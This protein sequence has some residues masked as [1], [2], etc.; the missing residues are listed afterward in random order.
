MIDSYQNVNGC[1][2]Y[3]SNP[4]TKRE[5]NNGDSSVSTI[6]DRHDSDRWR[7]TAELRE[8][9]RP[10]TLTGRSKHE[11]RN[12]LSNGIWSVG[13]W[14]SLHV[15]HQP[16]EWDIN[17]SVHRH[18]ECSWFGS[19]HLM[20]VHGRWFCP[21][22]EGVPDGQ[23]CRFGSMSVGGSSR[24][25]AYDWLWLIADERLVLRRCVSDPFAFQQQNTCSNDK[26]DI[27]GGF[28]HWQDSGH[29]NGTVVTTRWR[30]KRSIW[31][32]VGTYWSTATISSKERLTCGTRNHAEIP[33]WI[34]FWATHAAGIA[35][36]RAICTHLEEEEGNFVISANWMTKNRKKDLSEYAIWVTDERERER[37]RQKG[38]LFEAMGYRLISMAN[39][40]SLIC[41]WGRDTEQSRR[42]LLD[43]FDICTKLSWWFP[44]LS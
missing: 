9:R 20:I 24:D 39:F 38:R 7:T 40:S 8:R 6:A 34:A 41:Q 27:D 13:Y 36:N 16:E 44:C 22:E 19:N 29:R 23:S 10:S 32:L 26:S 18:C 42:T 17:R 31:Q 25:A 33:A 3:S 4:S 28:V 14:G 2:W 35:W 30:W 37:E 21:S 1:H 43:I 15:L 5:V 12:A 11:W